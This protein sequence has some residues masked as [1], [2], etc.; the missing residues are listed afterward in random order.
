[1]LYFGLIYEKEKVE[2]ENQEQVKKEKFEER[3]K[4]AEE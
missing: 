1:M 4:E 2:I 3:K